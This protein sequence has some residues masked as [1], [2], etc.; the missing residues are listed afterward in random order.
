[1]REVEEPIVSPFS[2]PRLRGKRREL[3]RVRI[4]VRYSTGR[5][6]VTANPERFSYG[7]LL[8]LKLYGSTGG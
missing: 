5:Q 1:M 8:T 7:K 6:I 3:P 2:F 4:E